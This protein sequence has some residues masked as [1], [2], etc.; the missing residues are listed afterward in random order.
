MNWQRNNLQRKQ[1]LSARKIRDRAL[2]LPLVGFIM[3]IPPVGGI[4]QL[5]VR[6]AGI[7]FTML[8]LFIVWGLLIVGAALLS[9][10]LHDEDHSERES[11][12]ASEAHE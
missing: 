5:D 9:K 6:I 4:F 1:L 7:P 8:Y 10:Q 12:S 2:I 11:R 3:L